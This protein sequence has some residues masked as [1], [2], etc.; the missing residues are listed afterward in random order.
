MS[1]VKEHLERLLNDKECAEKEYQ[2]LLELADEYPDL[3]I[4][5]T[6]WKKTK[7]ISEAVNT[8]AENCLLYHSCGCCDDSALLFS[9]ITTHSN[10]AEIHAKP[11]EICIGQ[12]DSSMSKGDRLKDSWKELLRTYNINPL[13]IDKIEVEFADNQLIVNETD[14]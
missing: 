2:R 12:K 13:L 5:T 3:E 6:R 14:I 1:Q 11:A 9:A 10:G 4:Y 8:T 7:Y